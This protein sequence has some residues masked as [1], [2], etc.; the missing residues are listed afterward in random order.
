[1]VVKILVPAAVTGLLLSAAMGAA[2]AAAQQ[3][4]SLTTDSSF[5]QMAGSV[6]LVQVK[7]GKLAEKKGS[8]A[9]VMEFGRQMVTDYSKA[10]E[11]LAGAAKQAAFPAP[12]LLRQHQ[13]IV[14]RFSRMGRSSFDKDY[15][16]EVVK[17]HSEVVRLFQQESES[18]RI[19]SLKQLAARMLP[20]LQQRLTLATQTAGSVGAD[21][22]ASSSETKQGSSSN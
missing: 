19:Q 13:Q 8:S 20:E 7:L 11:E 16:A 14:D 2:P 17:H 9:A 18:G 3:P 5:I 21:V 15:M 12:V 4:V 6:G 22:T 1:M 10:N